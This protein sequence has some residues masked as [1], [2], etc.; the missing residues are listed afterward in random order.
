MPEN[1]SG[2]VALIT[3]STRGIGRETA[4]TLARHG[5]DIVVTGKSTEDK[6]NLPGTIFSVAQEIEALGRR[7]LPAALDVRDDASVDAVVEATLRKFGRIDI[8]INN[9]GALWWQPMLE[10]PMKRYDLINDINSRGAFTC[11]RAVLPHML[12]A[13][14][15]HII[16]CSPP[17]DLSWLPDKVAYCISKFGMT[18]QVHGIAEEVRG[19]GVALNALWPVTAVESYATINFKMGDAS[20]W[21][22][23]SILA[24]AALMIVRKDPRTFTGHALLDEDFM[25]AEGV[26]DFTPYRCDPDVEPPRLMPTDIPKIGLVPR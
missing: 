17:V 26:T 1:L 16:N 5:C 7:A 11:T 9:A 18:M 21:R 24:D 14:W 25:R 12:Q 19:S 13:G 23:A 3:G 8:L 6:P 4:L 10:T 15:G 20:T 22:K 2:R